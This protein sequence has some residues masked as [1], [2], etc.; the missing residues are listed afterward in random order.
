[1]KLVHATPKI[2]IVTAES[3]NNQLQNS[4]INPVTHLVI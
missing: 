2:S 4:V 1:M 3:N